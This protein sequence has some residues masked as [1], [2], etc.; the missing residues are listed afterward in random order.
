MKRAR[1][2]THTEDCQSIRA[3][4]P[5]IRQLGVVTFPEQSPHHPRPASFRFSPLAAFPHSVPTQRRYESP[6]ERSRSSQRHLPVDGERGETRRGPISRGEGAEARADWPRRAAGPRPPGR[7]T[8]CDSSGPHWPRTGHGTGCTGLAGAARHGG[9]HRDAGRHRA[10]RERLG[11]S[12]AGNQCRFRASTG[13]H[14]ADYADYARSAHPPRV[15]RPRRDPG[16]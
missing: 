4:R 2:L 16:L 9:K 3:S 11:R 12:R 1:A 5:G 7:G 13:H 8:R 10:E 6:P 14:A 15:P